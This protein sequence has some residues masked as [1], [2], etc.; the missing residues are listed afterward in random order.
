M[1]LSKNTTILLKPMI[2]LQRLGR[3]DYNVDLLKINSIQAHE[4]YFDSI[5]LL[6]YI[7]TA[8]LPTRLSNNSLMP[9]LE[10]GMDILIHKK[11]VT[12]M[13]T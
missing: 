13:I 9:L 5:L 4:E 6:D 12:F 2:L 7:P 8:T 11:D 3:E 1:Y 10:N